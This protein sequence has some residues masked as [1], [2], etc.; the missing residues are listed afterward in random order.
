MAVFARRP[1]KVAVLP[2]WPQGG[3]SLYLAVRLERNHQNQKK[4]SGGSKMNDTFLLFGAKY[5]F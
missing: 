2:R 5:E 3:V 1:K 4:S